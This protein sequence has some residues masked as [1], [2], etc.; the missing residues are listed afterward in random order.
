MFGSVSS[1]VAEQQHFHAVP[2]PAL[3]PL[4][5]PTFLNLKLLFHLILHELMFYNMD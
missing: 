2:A 3:T 5:K 1:S 4:R